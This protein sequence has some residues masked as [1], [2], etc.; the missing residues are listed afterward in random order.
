MNRLIFGIGLLISLSACA[1]GPRLPPAPKLPYP[2]WYIGFAAPKHMEVWV[3]TVDVLDTRGLAF[4]RVHGGVASYTGKVEGWHQGVSGG[5]PINNVDL[6][7]QIFLRWQSLVEPQAYRARIQIPQ[8]VRDEMVRPERVYCRGSKEWIED[9]RFAITLGM[10]PGGIVK[11]WVGGPCLG[12]KE[13]G[14]YQA[15]VEPLGPNQ[16][17]RGLFYRAPN[18][19]AQA[20]IDQHGIPYGS[21]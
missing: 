3:E 15:K 12:F 2:A 14:R 4:F 18:P 6:P 10:A 7:D 19:A 9:Y 8:W 17:G 21:W 1:S 13:V 11:V 16:D 5:K 20:W